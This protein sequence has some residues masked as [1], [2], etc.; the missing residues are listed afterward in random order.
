MTTKKSATK[1]AAPAATTN[2]IP[3]ANAALIEQIVA[4]T[5]KG[6]NA[7]PLSWRVDTAKAILGEKPAKA[8][9]PTIITKSRQQ[10]QQEVIDRLTSYIKKAGM[11]KLK[12]LISGDAT[13]ADALIG[14]TTKSTIQPLV[15]IP[16]EGE[17]NSLLNKMTL[18]QL[19]S[20][21]QATLTYK[22]VATTTTKSTTTT[23]KAATTT[24][25]SGYVSI[26]D[27]EAYEIACYYLEQYSCGRKWNRKALA[28]ECL[29]GGRT[30]NPTMALRRF[31]FSTI[32]RDNCAIYNS[33]PA[34]SYEFYKNK[35]YLKQGEDAKN[36][37]QE[38][39]RE[40][41]DLVAMIESWKDEP[42]IK[43]V[44]KK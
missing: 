6:K 37:L 32:C 38:L 17:Y 9:K 21:L 40:E 12:A 35:P 8:A 14:I 4:A 10:V 36:D 24:K 5:G 43:A 29:R 34:I 19:V 15:S 20:M 39:L 7:C 30:A 31:L 2:T 33:M 44:L 42:Y 27:K 22:P 25:S 11:P 23:T 16:T 13:V 18:P 28:P 26:P 41:P 3:A 1:K